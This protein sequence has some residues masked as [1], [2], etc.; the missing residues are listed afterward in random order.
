VCYLSTFAVLYVSI[1]LVESDSLLV[2]FLPVCW[3]HFAVAAKRL[4]DLDKSAWWLVPWLAIP[5]GQILLGILQGTPGTNRYGENPL[6]PYP[7]QQPV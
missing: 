7:I 5:G 1:D 4:H 3:M 2:L 6:E